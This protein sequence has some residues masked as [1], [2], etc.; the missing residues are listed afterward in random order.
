M[1]VAVAVYLVMPV[2]GWLAACA[3]GCGIG[4]CTA[5]VGANCELALPVP[6]PPTHLHTR[7]PEPSPPAHPPSHTRFTPAQV[8][9]HSK[10]VL[11]LLGSW[12]FLGEK[13]SQRKLA[14]MVL[15][16]GGMVW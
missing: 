9:G 8:M 3:P 1:A 11:V 13:M 4:R 5:A 12:L 15:A 16:V 14:G 6:S 2:A 7:M 10:T